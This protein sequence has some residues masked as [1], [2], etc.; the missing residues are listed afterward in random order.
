[1]RTLNT[2][3]G[4]HRLLNAFGTPQGQEIA[5]R[6]NFSP[7]RCILDVAGGT[8]SLAVQV[9]LRYPHLRGVVMDLPPVRPF[10]EEH[11]RHNGLGDRFTTA[12]ADLFSGPYPTGADVVLLGHILHDWGDDLCRTILHHC[13]DALPPG[14]VLLICE[15]V[16]N[17]DFSGRRYALMLDLHMLVV[18]ASGGRERTEAEYRALKGQASEA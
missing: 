6:F 8:G 12:T 3:G 13:F 15:P 17:E 2:C 16:L 9:G 10:A 5:E 7:Y 4:S 18:S 11:I 1:M 14:G